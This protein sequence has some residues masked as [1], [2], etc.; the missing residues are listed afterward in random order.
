MDDLSILIK[1]ESFLRLRVIG[2]LPLI[3]LIDLQF[4]TLSVFLLLERWIA[5]MI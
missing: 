2:K 3:N 4:L 5:L 1:V